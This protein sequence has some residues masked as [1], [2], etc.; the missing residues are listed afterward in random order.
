MGVCGRESRVSGKRSRGAEWLRTYFAVAQLLLLHGQATKTKTQTQQHVAGVSNWARG[1]VPTPPGA[2]CDHVGH[3]QDGASI[4]TSQG[5]PYDGG[6]GWSS[7]SSYSNNSNDGT[8]RH[9]V[10]RCCSTASCSQTTMP[11][12]RMFLGFTWAQVGRQLCEPGCDS[13]STTQLLLAAT[14]CQPLG[15]RLWAIHRR[16]DGLRVPRDKHWMPVG[17][18]RTGAL[19]SRP[20]R[21]HCCGTMAGAHPGPPRPLERSRA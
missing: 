7:N 18:S 4:R 5:D 19:V 14:A 17:W 13:D 2:K 11:P 21:S 3:K 10:S 15:L 9:R 8:S 6:D 12:W 16:S 1:C 20:T